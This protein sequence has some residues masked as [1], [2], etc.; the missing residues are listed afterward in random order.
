VSL[1]LVNTFIFIDLKSTKLSGHINKYYIW[2][3][4]HDF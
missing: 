3:V 4:L 2:N 1:K